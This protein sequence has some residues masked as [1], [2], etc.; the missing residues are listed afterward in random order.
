[1][2]L[3]NYRPG[4]MEKLGL[5]YEE[6]EKINPSIIYAAVSGFGHTG[7][8]SQ[9]AAYD[10]IVQA[11]GGIMSLT[12][13]PDGMPTRVGASVENAIARYAVSGKY[14]QSNWQSA[15]FYQS[16]CSIARVG[17]TYCSCGR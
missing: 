10:L 8:Y 11:M 9:R 5:G 14:S 2:V 1:M 15:S 4:T 16:V 17:W 12:G 13:E 7:P 6:L 3:E